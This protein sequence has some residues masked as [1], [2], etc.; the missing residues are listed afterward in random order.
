VKKV[1]RDF[2]V[3]AFLFIFVI[4]IKVNNI[5]AY[6]RLNDNKTKEENLKLAKEYGDQAK[7]L[8]ARF[9]A[10]LD[11]VNKEFKPEYGLTPAKERKAKEPTE[12]YNRL[13]TA[14][15]TY[16]RIKST[17]E[18][19]ERMEKEKQQKAEAEARKKE[20]EAKQSEILNQAI[21]YCLEN[22]RT[23]GDALMVENAIQVANDIA[24]Q[25]EVSRREAEIGDGYIGFGGQ[26]CDDPCEGWNP[27][28]R[29]CQCGNRRVS[30]TEGW[31]SD[32]RN[33]DIYAEAY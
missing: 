21:A 12:A 27:K 23:F 20:M 14:T 22:G 1:S 31:S 18:T 8:M 7:E 32:F 11:E 19:R 17:Y 5:M 3:S 25:K 4:V 15:G 30:W 28:D 24:F 6:F 16:S 10:I 26:N 33:M 9:D 13:R 2:L 29:R